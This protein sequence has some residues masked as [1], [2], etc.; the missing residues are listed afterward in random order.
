MTGFRIVLS[1][2]YLASDHC[3][4]IIALD[5][6]TC[7]IGIVMLIAESSTKLQCCDEDLVLDTRLKL[8]DIVFW[9]VRTPDVQ[10]N[11]IVVDATVDKE[12]SP[13]RF[14]FIVSVY[15]LIL[16]INREYLN[17][18]VFGKNICSLL[19]LVRADSLSHG[20]LLISSWPPQLLGLRIQVQ[21]ASGSFSSTALL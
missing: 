5:F 15:P 11:G 9:V 14:A 19:D 4:A 20:H 13:L 21:Y 3:S 1:C 18:K 2:S 17:T 10:S 8:F 16:H 12:A 7:G 6:E